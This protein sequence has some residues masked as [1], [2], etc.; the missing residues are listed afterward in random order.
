MSFYG[1][2]GIRVVLYRIDVNKKPGRQYKDL[3]KLGPL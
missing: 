1:V 2:V 3:K